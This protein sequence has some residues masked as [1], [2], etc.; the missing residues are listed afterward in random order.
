MPILAGY[1]KVDDRTIAMTTTRVASYF[2]YMVVYLLFTSPN[3]LEQGG[4]DWA[5][6]A[7]L[8]PAGTGPFRLSRF[9]PRVSAELT[10]NNGYWDQRRVPKLD[11]VLLLPIPEANSRLAALR[12]GQVDWIEVPPPDAIPSLRAANFNVVTNCY[13]HVWPWQFQMGGTVSPFRD[14]R[15]RQALN[16]CVDRAGL[17]QLLNGTAE[18]SRRLAEA[19]RSAFRQPAAPLRLR[20]RPGQGA[21]GRGR[22][23][24]RSTR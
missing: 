3:S 19:L 9:T 13:P 7:A 11:R 4:R 10:K 20:S 2:P 18:P 5:K 12:S 6:V 24:A 17:V 21:A 8:P 16:Y 1:R 22:L 14:I 15:V 23:Y